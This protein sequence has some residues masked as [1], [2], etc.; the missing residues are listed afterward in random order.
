[1]S[2]K[3]KIRERAKKLN[4]IDDLMFRK[5]AEEPGFCEEILRVIL[6]DPGL[7]VRESIPEY[8]GTNLQ[9][10]SVVLDARCVLG[11][12]QQVDIEVQ[13][14]DDDDHQRRV[15]YNGSILT[16][17]IADPG[18]QFKAVPDVCGVF[19]SRFDLFEGGHVRYHVDR[20]AREAGKAVGNGFTEVYVNAKVKDGSD[21][22]ELMEVF[23]RDDAYSDKFPVTSR[24]KR[25]YKETE[26]GQMV[27]CEVVEQIVNELVEEE[28]LEIRRKGRLEGAREGRLEGIREGKLEGIREGKLEGIREGKLEGRL[29][30]KKATAIRL[31]GMGH[32]PDYAASVLDV[33]IET[34]Q[35]WLEAN[36]QR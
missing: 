34:I 26:E 36:E 15:R 2:N 14:R 25:R 8:A 9:G 30:E 21:V 24:S 23:T 11:D 1:M 6:A 13:K 17:N 29:E 4:P 27:M 22:A 20:V 10:R 5:M 32:P 31:V 19:I 35:Q 18:I 16:A 7:E 28:L 33:D 3:A 12:G